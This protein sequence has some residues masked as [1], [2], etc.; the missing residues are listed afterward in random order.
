MERKAATTGVT[1]ALLTCLSATGIAD[2]RH[3]QNVQFCHATNRVHAVCV[4]S[5]DSR[6]TIA[7]DWD[8]L[9]F[10]CE[11]RRDGTWMARYQKTHS[12]LG[13][14]GTFSKSLH[15]TLM[16]NVDWCAF[17]KSRFTGGV[18]WNTGTGRTCKNTSIDGAGRSPY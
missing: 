9:Y 16:A 4:S 1:A 2:T 13:T 6:G 11:L 18:F 14:S 12:G 17:N 5:F 10:K 8:K 15:A 3:T 7:I